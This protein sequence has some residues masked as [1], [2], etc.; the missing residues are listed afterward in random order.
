MLLSNQD[1]CDRL[2]GVRVTGARAVRSYGRRGLPSERPPRLEALEYDLDLRYDTR[3][4]QLVPATQHPIFG[5][6]DTLTI[7]GQSAD[8]TTVRVASGS[9][10]LQRYFD[11]LLV[12]FAPDDAILGLTGRVNIH[13][14]SHV[15]GDHSISWQEDY[16]A[17]YQEF[18][19]CSVP[20]SVRYYVPD[21]TTHVRPRIEISL[22][23]SL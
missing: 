8:T 22:E 11:E 1:S 3:Y 14:Y 21:D 19:G 20:V 4:G 10:E 16:V 2:S 12:H 9:A 13:G 6:P 5:E 23:Y 15:T 7:V 18:D 17:D